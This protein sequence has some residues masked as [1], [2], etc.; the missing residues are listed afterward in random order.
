MNFIK[1]AL[2]STKVKWGRSLLL[3]AVFTA[4]LVFVLAG[5]TIRSAAE[6]AASEA[7]K[8]VGATVTLSANREA[9]FQK[10]AETATSETDS[11]GTAQ[12]RIDPG[13]FSLTP[14]S[15]EDAQKIADLTD[16]KSYSFESSASALASD[17]ITAIS[18]SDSTDSSAESTD[19][20]Q[21]MGGDMPGGGQM[22]QAD[23]QVTGV[24]TSAQ[25]STFSSGTA[26]ITDGEGIDESDKDTNQV[27]IEQTLATANDLAVGDTFTITS[28]EDE[29]T[30]YELTVKGIYESSASSNSMGMQF[31]MMN[32]SNTLYTSYTLANELNGTAE[33]NTIDSAVYTL[34]DP[35]NMDDFLA[36]AK[37]LIDTDTFSLQS[38]DAAYQS[39]LEP[40]N[41]VAS[42]SK[43]VVLLVAV[44]GIIILT[45]IIMITIRERRHELGVLLSLGESRIKIILQL[46]TEVALCM[47]LALGVA[48]VSGNVVANV[49]G[50][51]LLEQ[52]TNSDQNTQTNDAKSQRPDG[53][54]PGGRGGQMGAPGSNSNPFA[55]SDEVSELSINV[56]PTQIGFLALVALGISLLSVC[57]ASIGILRL[58]P[59]KILLN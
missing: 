46:F 52:Q 23:F 11:D 19:A 34:A 30:T 28:S 4:I 51:Q 53:E 43:N 18:S 6:Q 17:G 35:E 12:E 41:N 31:S 5:L 10:P 45:L 48:A 44:A 8:E 20:N 14:V 47:I 15:L 29:E 39:M 33:D 7:Q 37:K 24:L 16:V 59:R 1:R 50:Q 32:P 42:F 3:F 25:N 36:K 21:P 22:T 2:K 54:N 55:V 9:S 57:L 27:L 56:T 58:N 26:T 38:N 49:V 40:L 13:S